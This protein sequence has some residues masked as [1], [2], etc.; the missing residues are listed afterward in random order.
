MD[1]WLGVAV[2]LFIGL[3]FSMIV[4]LLIVGK[5]YVGDLREDHSSGDERPYYFMEIARG[6]YRQMQKNRF[7]LLRIKRENYVSQSN[8]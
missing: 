3:V 1:I 2:G 7:V 6:G 8:E 4:S 5:W